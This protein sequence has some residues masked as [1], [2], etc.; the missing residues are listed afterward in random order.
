[1]IFSTNESNVL[2]VL[3]Y[4]TFT[5]AGELASQLFVSNKTI[6]RLVKKINDIAQSDYQKPLI[7]SETGK[8][9]ILNPAFININIQ[10]SIDYKEENQLNDL[11][12]SLMYKH[13]N[14]KSREAFKFEYVSESTAERLMKK[15][16]E[17]LLAYRIKLRM[18][19]DYVWIE[20]KEQD[21]RKAIHEI[22]LETHNLNA[23][24]EIGIELNEFDKHFLDKQLALLEESIGET[25]N[26]PYDITLYTHLYM[27]LKRYREGDV[28]YLQRQE[29]LE[30]DE[31]QLLHAN[32]RLAEVARQIKGNIERYLNLEL[33]EMEEFFIF[34]NLYSINI[35]ERES[36]NVDKSLAELISNRLITS[37][38]NISDKSLL[39]SCRSLYE[40]I[41]Q[42]T[43]PMLSRLRSGITVE[44]NLLEEEKVEYRDTFYKLKAIITEINKELTF[45]TKINE[46]EI[47]YLTL[48]FE[49]YKLSKSQAKNVLL[50]CSTGIGT[51]ELLKIRLEKNV[52]NI[53]IVAAMSQR[54]MK[55][56][57]A[58]LNENIDLILSTLRVPLNSVNLPVLTISP[59]LTS[60]DIQKINYMLKET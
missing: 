15:L 44:N 6:Y 21:I 53:N 54:Q 28:S 43:L 32:R 33:S 60:Q 29:P 55:N 8:G 42:H 11:L 57:K 30:V 5:S 50:V 10:Q 20:G 35:Q 4:E 56:N 2:N 26:Y 39:P 45:E 24:G 19:L 58:F 48:Y 1:M 36:S 13:P 49:K 25:I 37:F 3:N 46:E 18:N 52:Q 47:G 34:Q 38:F 7:L 14:K 40:D 23:L 9:Y 12:L 17:R 27:L 51:S 16:E 41:Y 22:I 59:L 31:L